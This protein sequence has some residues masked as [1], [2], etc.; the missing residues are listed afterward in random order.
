MANW[1]TP[2]PTIMT[3][4][5]ESVNGSHFI[6]LREKNT[7]YPIIVLKPFEMV[8]EFYD[9]D[10]T[11][12]VPDLLQTEMIRIQED[13]QWI[14]A[15]IP[16][17]CQFNPMSKYSRRYTCCGFFAPI[18]YYTQ[19][20]KY[21]S[22]GEF[23]D[24]IDASE[25]TRLEL[26]NDET[27]SNDNGKRP[28]YAMSSVPL[29][30][31]KM[32][33]TGGGGKPNN[34]DE[35]IIERAPLFYKTISSYGMHYAIKQPKDTKS[36]NHN[37][38]EW[39]N[40]NEWIE[41]KKSKS[42]LHPGTSYIFNLIG[43][44]P[45]K[46]K[47]GTN[48]YS[49]YHHMYVY[50]VRDNSGKIDYVI[51]ADSWCWVTPANEALK[52]YENIRAMKYADFIEVVT[53]INMASKH[54]TSNTQEYMDSSDFFI[55]RMFF[56]PYGQALYSSINKSVYF[57]PMRNKILSRI[58]QKLNYVRAKREI[59]KTFGGNIFGEKVFGGKTKKLSNPIKYRKH[60]TR[61]S[62]TKSVKIER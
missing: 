59:T 12:T 52:R 60:K 1:F 24:Q 38:E 39:H 19:R 44:E 5:N 6:V 17:R 29:K 34:T 8:S 9:I 23:D 4:V 41:P 45:Y 40:L 37:T 42:N 33:M 43:R 14:K 51:M 15:N 50:R 7:G 10:N 54:F 36:W 2:L 20:V 62:T 61:R 58:I 53:K 32:I 47:E 22:E 11:Y 56:V 35:Q 21:A 26:G 46:M 30:K 18:L 28:A 55:S 31:R 49:T 48:F 3:R 16:E 13:V 27:K 57:I 25:N